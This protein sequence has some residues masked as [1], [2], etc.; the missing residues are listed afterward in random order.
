MDGKNP[1]R[2][3]VTAAVPI[4]WLSENP[5]ESDTAAD[6]PAGRIKET[7]YANFTAESS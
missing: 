3:H 4:F 6:I 1:E 2:R 7:V 5:R